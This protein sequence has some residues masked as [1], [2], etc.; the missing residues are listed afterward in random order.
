MPYGKKYYD[1][2]H[3]AVYAGARKLLRVNDKKEKKKIYAWLSNQDGYT[4]H[5][6][7]KRRFPRL[8]YNVT[9]ID[10]VWK[11]DLLQLTSIKDY[12]DG[13]CY[14]LEVI[15]VLGKFAWVEPLKDKTARNVA[16]AFEKILDRRDVQDSE[17]IATSKSIYLHS[18]RLEW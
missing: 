3:E 11:C 2:E 12:N 14:I 9:N 18:R 7:I 10:D 1:L 15:D 8:S 17:Y 6:P 4:L 13:Y 16:S 5:H